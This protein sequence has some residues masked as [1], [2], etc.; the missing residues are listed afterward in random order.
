MMN[1]NPI[2]YCLFNFLRTQY[3]AVQ[4]DDKMNLRK[5]MYKMIMWLLI[6]NQVSLVYK[7]DRVNLGKKAELQRVTSMDSF[8][9]IRQARHLRLHN[10]QRKIG[11]EQSTKSLQLIRNDGV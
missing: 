8:L 2:Y 1:G 7:L 9:P 4:L 5:S 3:N 11:H 10:K 6:E